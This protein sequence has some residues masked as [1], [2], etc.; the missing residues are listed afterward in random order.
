[1]AKYDYNCR[2]HQAISCTVLPL[3]MRKRLDER[4]GEGLREW[5]Q[6]KAWVSAREVLGK[7]AVDHPG[8]HVLSLMGARIYSINPGDLQ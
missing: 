5:C 3:A 4:N 1:M 2:P 8:C 6:P 7:G